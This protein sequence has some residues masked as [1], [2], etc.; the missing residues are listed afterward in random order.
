V[1][2]DDCVYFIDN[3]FVISILALLTLGKID[4][5]SAK[6][7]QKR[8]EKTLSPIE[9]GQGGEYHDAQEKSG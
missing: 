7:T 8:P 6:K 2:S 4:F 1:S 3:Q 5:F 9:G